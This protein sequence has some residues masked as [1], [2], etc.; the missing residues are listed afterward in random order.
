[1]QKSMI[2]SMSHD[3]CDQSQAF[4]SAMGIDIAVPRFFAKNQEHTGKLITAE[5]HPYY[6]R[7]RVYVISELLLPMLGIIKVIIH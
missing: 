2:I 4:H 7:M 6:V 1:M 3:G 5:N